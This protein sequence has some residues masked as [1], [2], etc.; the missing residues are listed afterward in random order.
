MYKRKVNR[1]NTDIL[2]QIKENTM[3]YNIKVK[4]LFVQFQYAFDKSQECS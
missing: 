1:C 2:A 3:K 4:M